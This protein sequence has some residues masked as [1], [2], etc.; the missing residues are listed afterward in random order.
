MGYNKFLLRVAK[1]WAPDQP[2]IS[3][4]TFKMKINQQPVLHHRIQQKMHSLAKEQATSQ[5]GLQSLQGEDDDVNKTCLLFTQCCTSYYTKKKHYHSI[6][7][8]ISTFS[9]IEKLNCLQCM[10]VF[11]CSLGR[12]N[13]GTDKALAKKYSGPQFDKILTILFFEAKKGIIKDHSPE[14]IQKEKF[15]NGEGW[16]K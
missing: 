2:P 7:Q 11:W 6:W 12:N 13:L 8:P 10:H 3:N 9:K 14:L 4:G 15:R 5:H 16:C 1:Y